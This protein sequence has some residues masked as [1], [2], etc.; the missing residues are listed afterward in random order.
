MS[1]MRLHRKPSQFHQMST[2]PVAAS[3]L[4]NKPYLQMR[5]QRKSPPIVDNYKLRSQKPNLP[6]TA[7]GGPH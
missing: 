4:I 7:S 1:E 6:P 3:L 5:L 2:I